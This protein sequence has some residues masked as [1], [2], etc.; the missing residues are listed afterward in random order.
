MNTNSET[1]I[2]IEDIKQN[3]ENYRTT[4]H[5]LQALVSIVTW[6]KSDNQILEGAQ[7]SFGRRM[8]TS[9][10]NRI[11]PDHYV[12][13]DIVIQRTQNLGYVVEAKKS[14]PVNQDY[15]QK[16]VFQLLKYDDDLL[17]W[18]TND[19]LMET[20]CLILLLHQPRSFDFRKYLE[21]YLDKESIEF[22]NKCS[23][24]EFNR[25]SEVKEFIFLRKY[26]GS[27][28]DESISSG[29]ESGKDVPVEKVLV[30]YGEKKFYDSEPI[31]EYIMVILWQ[32]L[33]TDMKTGVEY[34]EAHKAW[35]LNINIDDL[36]VELQKLFGSESNEYREIK[37]PKTSWV[38]KAMDAFVKIKLAKKANNGKDYKVLFKYLHGDPIEKFS[39]H[40][41]QP[42]EDIGIKAEQLTFFEEKYT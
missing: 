14:L 18:W 29:L 37:Y 19:E 32:D 4:I 3:I 17:G 7:T 11:M 28:C 10:N 41:E 39:K 22:K 38:R 21:D 33:F 34:N 24:V 9:P 13:P 36:T 31:I 8:D 25:S 15:W 12:T 1:I 2:N 16:T 6:D 35:L 27:I 40:R 26:W 42:D 30:S 23:I 20:T 5:A